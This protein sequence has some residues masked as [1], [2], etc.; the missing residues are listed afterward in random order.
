M[1]VADAAELGLGRGV[2]GDDRRADVDV[3][4]E[5]PGEHAGDGEGGRAQFEHRAAHARHVDELLDDPRQQQEWPAAKTGVPEQALERS[6]RRGQQGERRTRGAPHDETAAALGGEQVA[7]LDL[8]Y[9]AGHEIG[10]GR[11]GGRPR[12]GDAHAGRL[13][14]GRRGPCAVDGVDDQ[15]ELGVGGALQAAVFGVVGPARQARRHVVGQ[16]ALGDLV[17][18]EGHVAAHGFAGVGAGGVQ[19]EERLHD[20]AQAGAEGGELGHDVGG[21]GHLESL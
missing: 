9:D 18:L 4:V 3:G 12:G 11:R 21:D 19:S 13:K 7:G 5:L 10:H 14:A 16:V 17:D 8:L 2:R 20:L 15:Y 6:A 1:A